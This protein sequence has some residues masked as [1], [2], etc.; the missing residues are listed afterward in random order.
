MLDLGTTV[1][2]VFALGLLAIFTCS[3]AID[4]HG[5][6]DDLNRLVDAL[7]DKNTEDRP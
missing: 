7:D 5:I 1:A 4:L 3:I 2:V 6:K